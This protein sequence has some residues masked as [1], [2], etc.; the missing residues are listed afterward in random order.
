[1]AKALAAKLRQGGG[2]L[3]T[4]LA[5]TLRQSMAQVHGK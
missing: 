3:D 1:V 4:P 2:G 5:Q